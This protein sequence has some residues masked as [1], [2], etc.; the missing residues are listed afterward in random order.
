M[1]SQLTLYIASGPG[2]F[3][4]SLSAAPS[5]FWRDRMATLP[6]AK[7]LTVRTASSSSRLSLSIIVATLSASCALKSMSMA[8]C[9]GCS[10]SSLVSFLNG[11]LTTTLPCTRTP[12]SLTRADKQGGKCQFASGCLGGRTRL[13]IHVMLR[14]LVEEE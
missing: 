9:T 7:L 13:C 8:A 6:C 14:C 1:K 4:R 12:V 10:T 2:F 5:A 11:A 3:L